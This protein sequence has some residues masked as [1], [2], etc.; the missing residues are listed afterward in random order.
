MKRKLYGIGYEVRSGEVFSCFI[1]AKN[2]IEARKIFYNHFCEP[3]IILAIQQV[4]DG[5]GEVIF[6]GN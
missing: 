5:K 2:E 1:S 6:Y 3:V 4:W